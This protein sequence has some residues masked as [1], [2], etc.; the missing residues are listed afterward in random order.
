[1]AFLGEEEEEVPGPISSPVESGGEE[2]V[3]GATRGILVSA[4]E[5]LIGRVLLVALERHQQH[6]HRTVWSWPERYTLSAQFLL[7]LP[8]HSSTLT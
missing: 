7:H 8:G 3:T 1:M 2:L 6:S 4:R 5:M